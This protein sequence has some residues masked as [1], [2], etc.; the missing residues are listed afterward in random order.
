MW[1]LPEFFLFQNRIVQECFSMLTQISDKGKHK[2][3]ATRH[4]KILKIVYFWQILFF[5]EMNELLQFELQ[6][7]RFRGKVNRQESQP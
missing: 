6:L 7:E 1:N 5:F 3:V 2:I 4:D